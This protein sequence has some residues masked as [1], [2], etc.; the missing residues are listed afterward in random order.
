MAEI[1]NLR[2]V[3]KRKAKDEAD[4]AAAKNRVL[5]GRTK[6]EKQFD[7][8]ATRKADRFLED[9]RREKPDAGKTD[10]K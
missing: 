2:R 8:A 10:G 9:N 4:K 7:Q 1:V 6:V 5:F 3:R